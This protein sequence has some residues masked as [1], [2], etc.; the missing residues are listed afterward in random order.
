MGWRH[1]RFHPRVMLGQHKLFVLAQGYPVR[2]ICASQKVAGTV[3]VEVSSLL[4]GEWEEVIY[5]CGGFSGWGKVGRRQNGT[6]RGHRLQVGWP[7]EDAGA[8]IGQL[9]YILTPFSGRHSPDLGRCQLLEL[10]PAKK[11]AQIQATHR[12]GWHLPC[13]KGINT[14]PLSS[15]SKCSDCWEAACKVLWAC[16]LIVFS[17][18]KMIFVW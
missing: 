9:C 18:R 5:L 3:Q 17:L 6:E 11:Q 14:P 10:E 16:R 12:H 13:G 1:L 2:H 15:F 4:C 7:R 8:R